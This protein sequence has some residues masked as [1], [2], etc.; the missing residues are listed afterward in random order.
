M[1]ESDTHST[2]PHLD[3]P[4]AIVGDV[5]IAAKF[6]PFRVMLFLTD[7]GP[8]NTFSRDT[9]GESYE[10]KLPRVPTKETRVIAA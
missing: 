7:V 8:L 4:I 2:V 9:T 5:F 10:K 3:D 1:V 6:T